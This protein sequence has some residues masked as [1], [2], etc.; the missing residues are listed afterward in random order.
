M[1]IDRL[2]VGVHDKEVVDGRTEL[3]RHTG[4]VT[5]LRGADC[6]VLVDT[7]ARGRFDEVALELEKRGLKVDDITAVILTHFHLDHAYNVSRFPRARVFAWFQEW[8][9][10]K[11]V[12]IDDIEAWNAY[13]DVRLIKTPGHAE[14][15]I[16]VITRDPEGRTVIIA[17]DAINEAY[18]RT[19][20]ISAFCYDEELY[21]RSAK[22]ILSL[23]DLIIPGHGEPFTP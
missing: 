5:L 15:H 20:V 12:R 3:P 16:S 22:R 19:G 21:H 2:I 13:D 23:A 11:T 4:A 10:G 6:A 8:C 17:G 18:A 9:D 7:G 14:E 1:I